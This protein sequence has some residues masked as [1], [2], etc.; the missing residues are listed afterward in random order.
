MSGTF[1][2][3]GAILLGG[4][5]GLLLKKAM[6]ERISA[7]VMR[8]VGL[9]TAVIA[10]WGLAG[11]MLTV[12]DGKIGSQGELL[13]L[14][15]LVIGCAAGELLR[16]DDRLNGVAARIERKFGKA[17][18]AD[19]FVSSSLVFAVGAM[20]IMGPLENV[21]YGQ[22]KILLVKSLLDF[23]GAVIFGATLGYGVLFS[24]GTV[25]A[26]QGIAAL[27]AGML[28][29]VPQAA[30][31]DFFMVGYAIVMCIGLN[32]LFSAKIKTANLLPAMLVPVLYNLIM[33]LKIL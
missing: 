28:S 5:I 14:V 3:A 25:F 29:G 4:I 20:S 2:N 16:L 7:P 27:F 32:F 19:A 17:G 24:A 9:A 10:L 11:V 18:F 30:M 33:M 8:M 13:L 23:V 21:L 1:I 26:V 22:V 6:P 31:N 15:S 12:E